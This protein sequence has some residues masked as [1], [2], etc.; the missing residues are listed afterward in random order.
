MR[1]KKPDGALALLR[2]SSLDVLTSSAVDQE[3][4]SLLLFLKGDI[5]GSRLGTNPESPKL[6]VVW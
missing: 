5:P 6:G 3:R 2:K 1:V 4:P